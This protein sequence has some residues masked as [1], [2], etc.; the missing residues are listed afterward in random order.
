MRTFFIKSIIFL[1]IILALLLLLDRFYTNY[2]ASHKNVC[3]K[4]DWVLNQYNKEFDFAFIGNSR[5]INGIDINEVEKVTKLTGINLGLTGA[6]YAE[7]YLLL[8]QFLKNGNKVRNLI[9]QIDMH[10]LRS[11]TLPYPFHNTNYMHLLSDPSVYEIYKDNTELYRL[12]L[13]KY[14]P[15]AR[16]MEFSS[17]FVLYKILKGGYECTASS[18]FDP[19]KGSDLHKDK[20][21]VPEALSYSYWEIDEKDQ[22]YLNKLV[23]FAKKQNMNVIFYTA[24]IFN[25]YYPY[26]L[27]LS[28]IIDYEKKM[29]QKLG[30]AYFDFSSPQNPLCSDVTNFND[31]IHM[32]VTGT[33]RF[34]ASIADS[35]KNKLN[36]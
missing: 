6:N 20:K 19:T 32:N 11:S 26:Q 24:P 3:E 33:Q 10:S 35:L 9:V 2:V 18:V 31:N 34:S 14:I 28:E 12:L 21:F 29:A 30:I 4:S 27:K 5:V 17:R 8:Q 25:G 16:Y 7:N 36:Q 15:F 13:W 1:S 23:A 22:K